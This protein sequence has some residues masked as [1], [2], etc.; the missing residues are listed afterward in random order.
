MS[1]IFRRRR[2]NDG[3]ENGLKADFPLGEICSR[4]QRKKRLDWLATNTDD[5]TSQSHSLFACS[6]EL[7]RQVENRL[8]TVLLKCISC[9]KGPLL[10]PPPPTGP[11][12]FG[13]RGQRTPLNGVFACNILILRSFV[14]PA[15]IVERNKDVIVIVYQSRSLIEM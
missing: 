4:E 12:I 1:K 3:V 2:R 10:A 5:I 9:K 8:N 11:A 6:R 14:F 7:I 15:Q 13:Q